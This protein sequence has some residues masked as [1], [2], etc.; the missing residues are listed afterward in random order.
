MAALKGAHGYIDREK[1]RRALRAGAVFCAVLVLLISGYIV[2][3]TKLN[4]FTFI[5]I[6]LCL[7]G[8]KILVQLITLLPYRSVVPEKGREAAENAG[9]LMILYETVITSSE[10]IMPV[11]ITAVYDNTVC[12]YTGYRKVDADDIGSYLK[13]MMNQNRLSDVSVKIFD[14]YP[15][16]LNRVKEMN[17]LAGKN[18]KDSKEEEEN[19]KRVLLNLSL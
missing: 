6:M 10:K 12:G 18:Q 13:T 1:K 17:R 8:A 15:A 5:A 19:I 16:F 14:D 9:A 2:N 7:P 3:G 11:E 4:W